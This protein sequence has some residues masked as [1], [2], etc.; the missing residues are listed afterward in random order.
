MGFPKDQSSNCYGRFM[1]LNY[2]NRRK[3][4]DFFLLQVGIPSWMKMTK[5]GLSVCFLLNNHSLQLEASFFYIYHVC[6]SNGCNWI[7]T[8]YHWGR[9]GGA[10][11]RVLYDR[12]W[13]HFCPI[14]WKNTSVVSL[15]SLHKIH[16]CIAHKKWICSSITEAVKIK[17]NKH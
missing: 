4:W 1:Q 3:M 16:T 17:E 2:Y 14:I 12:Q 11:V 5:R 7:G 10:T 15:Q 8:L 6:W 13:L 9:T